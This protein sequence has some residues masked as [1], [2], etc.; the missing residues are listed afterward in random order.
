MADAR[1]RHA[2]QLQRAVGNRA[3]AALLQRQDDDAP[4]T[5]AQVTKALSFY[6]AQPGRYT[7]EIITQIQGEVGVADSGSTDAAFVQAVAVWQRDHGDLHPTLWIDGMAGPRTLPRMFPSGLQATD[8]PESFGQD[9]QTGV[10]DRWQDLTVDQRIAELIRLV[11]A[12]LQ[13]AGVPAVAPNPQDTLDLGAFNFP[14]WTMIVGRNAMAV[15]QPNLAQAKD[16]VNTIYHEARHAEQWFRV[17]QLRCLQRRSGN[18]GATDARIAAAVAT[19]LGIPRTIA[20][21]A[22]K[23]APFA[24]GSM[25]A[26]IAQGWFDS[27]YGTGS[28]RREAILTELDNANK[29]LVAAQT[30]NRQHPSPANELAVERAQDRLSRA[31]A[32]HATLPEEDDAFVAGERAE[33]GITAGAPPKAPPVPAGAP[34]AP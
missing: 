9:A 26:L 30:R 34:G 32:G 14:D 20:G 15:E 25:D 18:P 6:A 10:I 17:A 16:L 4:L 2:L 12:R 29:Q 11:N 13:S 19:E 24:L 27:V 1:V 31:I 8:E 28:T 7:P 22:V 21:E 5:D 23:P 33:P 3:A